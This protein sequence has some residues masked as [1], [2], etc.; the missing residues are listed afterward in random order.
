M[1]RCGSH[2]DPGVVAI[3]SFRFDALSRHF[4]SRRSLLASIF[5]AVPVW[6]GPATTGAKHKKHHRRHKP[7]PKPCSAPCPECQ[8]CRNGVCVNHDGG[9]CQN[10]SCNHCEG[11]GCVLKAPNSPCNRPDHTIGKCRADGGCDPPPTCTQKGG[12]CIKGEDTNNCCSND[13]LGID[14]ELGTCGQSDVG[15]DCLTDAACNVGIAAVNFCNVQF[16]C[17]E[18]VI[19]GG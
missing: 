15:E 13:C 9:D 14:P 16:Q 4:A 12:G 3:D 2:S 1:Q 11:G 18:R 6:L 17:Q 7:K 8:T 5:A 10:S 19:G